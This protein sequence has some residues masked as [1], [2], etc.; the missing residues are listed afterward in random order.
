[1]LFPDS[2]RVPVP[3]LLSCPEPL[4]T[5]EIVLFDPLVFRVP[6]DEP[7]E[8]VLS[9]VIAVESFRVPPFS[10]TFPLPKLVSLDTESVPSRIFVPLLCVLFPDKVT[11][12]VPIL[13]RDVSL[14]EISY[15]AVTLLLPPTTTSPTGKRRKGAVNVPSEDPLLKLTTLMSLP[16]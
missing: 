5:P 12:P 4:T 16:A 10:V 2:V 9:V 15:E 13:T 7:T 6:F 3:L 11:V 14:S 1:M 8:I